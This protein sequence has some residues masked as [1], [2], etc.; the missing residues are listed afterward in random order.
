M[1]LPKN[2]CFQNIKIKSNSTTWMTLMS[3]LEISE[4]LEPL[5][6]Q[7]PLQPQQPPWPQW[8]QN[9]FFFK[10]LVN[11]IVFYTPFIKI[12]TT[13]P[14]LLN[15]L[16]KTPNFPISLILFSQRL[17]RPLEVFFFKNCYSGTNVHSL[18]PPQA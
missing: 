7:W 8:P 5:Q 3:S 16:T 12:S 18:R 17:L 14:F 2:N 4:T 9:P 1:I 11:F 15:L 6:P 10:T 13:D